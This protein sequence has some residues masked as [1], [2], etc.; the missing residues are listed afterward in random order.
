MKSIYLASGLGFSAHQKRKL[1]PDFVRILEDLGA[2]V[3]EPFTTNEQEVF[4]MRPGWAYRVGQRDLRSV[5]DCDAILVVLNGNPPDEGAMV[6]LGAAIALGKPTFLF[7][8]DFR[9]C[10]D[11]E[12]YQLNLM[13]FTGL[14]EDGWRDYWY[15]SLEEI[16]DP[17]KALARW[18]RGDLEAY[19]TRPAEGW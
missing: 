3:L 16:S 14:P 13:I 12:Q 10:A 19:V 9:R 15:T 7:R 2:E 18:L 11:C 1:L 8:D 4:H 6:E 17:D 5:V